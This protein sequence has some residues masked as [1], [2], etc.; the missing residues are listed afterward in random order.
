MERRE[1]IAACAAGSAGIKPVRNPDD[2]P[3]QFWGIV[4]LMGHVKMAGRVSEV[5]IAGSQMLRI[6]IPTDSGIV[7]Q[8]F[9]SGSVYRITPT[10]EKACRTVAST[11]FEPIYCEVQRSLGWDDEQ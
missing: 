10:T 11:G 5:Q 2:G 8:Y 1:F 3:L 4:E 6:E 9:P 7:T